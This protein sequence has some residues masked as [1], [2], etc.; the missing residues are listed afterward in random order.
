MY[1][2]DALFHTVRTIHCYHL[3]TKNIYNSPQQSLNIKKLA[4]S[5]DDKSR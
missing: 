1:Y 2:N 3:K 4:L 5:T